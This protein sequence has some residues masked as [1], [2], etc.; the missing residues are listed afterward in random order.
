MAELK[1]NKHFDKIKKAVQD[2]KAGKISTAEYN[3]IIHSTLKSI[4]IPIKP[5]AKGGIIKANKGT[6]VAKKKKK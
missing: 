5:K 3:K 1:E 4:T 2:R 6:A